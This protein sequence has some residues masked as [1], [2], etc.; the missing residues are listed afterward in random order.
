M[1]TSTPLLTSLVEGGL[2]GARTQNARE[3]EALL[4]AYDS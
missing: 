4:K 1:V 2:A 3:A